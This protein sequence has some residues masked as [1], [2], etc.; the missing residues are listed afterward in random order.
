MKLELSFSHLLNRFD[1]I[2]VSERGNSA[3]GCLHDVDMRLGKS[4][5]PIDELLHPGH[6]A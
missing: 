3:A 5:S 4:D 6:D 1:A 2:R